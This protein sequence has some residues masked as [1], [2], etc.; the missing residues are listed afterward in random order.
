[1]P[2]LQGTE[3]KQV[4]D[5]IAALGRRV[6]PADVATRTGLPILVVQQKLN[7]VAAETGGHL[8]VATAGDVAYKFKPGFSQAYIARGIK[9]TMLEIGEKVWKVLFYLI[10]ISFGIMLILSL[11][12]VIAAIVVLVTM[13]MRGGRRNGDDDSFSFGFGGLLG[14]GGGRGGGGGFNLSFFDL[15]VIRDLL[16]WNT[17]YYRPPVRYEYNKPTVRT[18]KQSNFLLNCFSFLFGDGDPNEGLDEKRW[19]LIAQVIKR[20]N[21]VLTAE[22]LA[23]Y[24]GKD[25]KNED[26]V[27]P[28]LVRFNGRP[29]VTESGNIIYVFESMQ[30]TA[31]DQY[32]NPEPYLREFPWK[33][34]DL[35]HSELSPVYIV[36]AL[37]FCGAWALFSWVHRTNSILSFPLI[38]G[39][40]FVLIPGIRVVFNHYRNKMIEER[41]MR[42]YRYSQM[43]DNPTPELGAKLKEAVSYRVRDRKI[44]QKDL[45]YTTE[46]DALDQ[47]DDLD[48]QFETLEGQQK[49][50]IGTNKTNDSPD[51]GDDDDDS[52]DDGRIISTDVNAG[53]VIDIRKKL[54]RDF[55]ASP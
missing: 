55:D 17:Y 12:I 43:L 34:T 15:M 23:P 51:I 14:G 26:S 37:N 50:A 30:S 7:E 2:M 18:R 52:E 25:P 10:R 36:A 5:A 41:N 33:F 3:K 29:E 28:V 53:N 42:R 46:K 47:K 31:A 13:M 32:H 8:Q 48:A 11:L 4:I 6:T 40:L 24:T 9:R 38:Y 21:N 49:K 19:Q 44:G 39:T 22:Q 16:M 1:M 54:Q 20:N 45:V 27:L 35:P